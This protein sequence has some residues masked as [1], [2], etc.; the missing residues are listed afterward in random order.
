[1]CENPVDSSA[2]FFAKTFCALLDVQGCFITR[3]DFQDILYL[4][5]KLVGKFLLK[6]VCHVCM[7]LEIAQLQRLLIY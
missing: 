2:G 3:L 1:M 4:S 5:L 6:Q 7:E